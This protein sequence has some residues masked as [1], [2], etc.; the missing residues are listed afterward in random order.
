MNQT[1]PHFPHDPTLFSHSR[2]GIRSHCLFGQFSITVFIFFIIPALR[3]FKF[4]VWKFHDN[5]FH[6]RLQK[7]I[8]LILLFQILTAVVAECLRRLTRNQMGFPRASSNPADC[9]V[10]FCVASRLAACNIQ[11]YHRHAIYRTFN[12][13][14]ERQLNKMTITV[15][16]TFHIK[17]KRNLLFL[18]YFL[19]QI[20]ILSS[21]QICNTMQKNTI[22]K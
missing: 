9:G 19:Y 7:Y 20:K 21:F 13:R 5:F 6:V 18:H 10:S 4:P 8:N 12:T 15:Q 16:K 22:K 17:Q 11:S 2:M 14:T 1:H 3:T